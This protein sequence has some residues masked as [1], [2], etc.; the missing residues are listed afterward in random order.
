M[1]PVHIFFGFKLMQKTLFTFLLSD[2]KVLQ[3]LIKRY[4]L[5]KCPFINS[6][7]VPYYYMSEQTYH[8]IKIKLLSKPNQSCRRNFQEFL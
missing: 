5:V 2:I 1:L 3:T 7:S 8:R 6:V 4:K